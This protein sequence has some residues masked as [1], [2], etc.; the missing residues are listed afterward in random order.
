MKNI[1]KQIKCVAEYIPI[2]LPKEICSRI[3]LIKIWNFLSNFTNAYQK[4][5]INLELMK[6]FV[7]VKKIYEILPLVNVQNIAES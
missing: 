1:F 2:G 5:K 7:I 4:K 6:M 3:Q